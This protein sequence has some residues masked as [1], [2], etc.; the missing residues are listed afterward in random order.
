[1]KLSEEPR[2]ANHLG[3]W[4]SEWE[5]ASRRTNVRLVVGDE[6]GAVQE[7]SRNGGH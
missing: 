5:G 2:A 6:D 3:G 4:R 1:M 7:A